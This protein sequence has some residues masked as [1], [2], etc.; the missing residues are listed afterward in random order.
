MRRRKG[1]MIYL[2]CKLERGAFLSRM[3]SFGA[4][5]WVQDK[6]VKQTAASFIFWLFH[7]DIIP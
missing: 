1:G 4:A 2:K 7:D 6:K 5:G 3:N